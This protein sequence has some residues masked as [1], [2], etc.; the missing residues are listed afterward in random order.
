MNGDNKVILAEL[1]YATPDF[2]IVKPGTH[3]TCAVT[4]RHIPVPELRYWSPELQEAYADADAAF[5][6]WLETQGETK[7]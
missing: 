2:T 5:A 1:K 7:K 6:R 4:G 3:V